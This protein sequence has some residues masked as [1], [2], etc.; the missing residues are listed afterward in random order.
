VMALLGQLGYDA[1]WMSSHA[2][3]GA[4]ES[5]WQWRCRG[6]L[7]AMRCKCQVMLV[8]VLPSHAGDGT[9][10][11]GCTG[12]VM[13]AQPSSSEHRGDVIVGRSRIGMPI[14]DDVHV[15]S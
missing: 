14:V 4:T 2:G 11:Q 9:T 15:G 3:D 6:D 10:A 8:T 7:V 13:L 12:C 1:M 5:C